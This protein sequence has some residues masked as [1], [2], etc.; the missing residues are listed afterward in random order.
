MNV[1]L[2]AGKVAREIAQ[3]LAK[4]TAWPVNYNQLHGSPRSTILRKPLPLL[5]SPLSRISPLARRRPLP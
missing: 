4:E 5:L 2:D 3:Q 1:S